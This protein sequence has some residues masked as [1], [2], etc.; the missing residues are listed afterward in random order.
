MSEESL[1]E[2]VA[3]MRPRDGSQILIP[4]EGLR[5]PTCLGE[6]LGVQTVVVD[7]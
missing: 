1:L 5:S 4:F 2:H 7:E 3:G 6:G